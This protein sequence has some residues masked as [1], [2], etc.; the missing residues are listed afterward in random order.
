MSAG[1]S[2]RAI[3]CVLGLLAGCATTSTT[4]AA[5]EPA[6]LRFGP[7]PGEVTHEGLECGELPVPG[8]LLAVSRLRATGD[9]AERRGILLVNPGG[10]GGPGLGYAATKGAKLPP[11]V[12]RSFDVIGFDPRGVGH[13]SPVDCGPMGG[14]FDR[15]GPDPVPRTAAERQTHLDRLAALAV[16]CREGADAALATTSTVETAQDMDR[17]RAALGE[18]QISFLGVSYGTYLGM[19]Y[20]QLFGERVD[21]MVLDSVVGPGEWYDFDL[22]QARALL[23]QREVLFGWLADRHARFGLGADPAQVRRSYDRARA[24]LPAAGLGPPGAFGRAEFD[25]V[26]YRMLGR[27]ERWT[28]FGDGLRAFLRDGDLSV[29][30]PAEPYGTPEDRTYESANRV[31]KCADTMSPP[32]PGRILA[33]L[34]ALLRRDPQPVLTGIEA[35]TCAYWRTRGEAAPTGPGVPVLLVQA[36]HDPVTPAEGALQVRDALPGS[37][38]V[39]LAESW[40]HG[41]FASQRD[42]CVDDTAGTYLLTRRLPAADVTC[43]GAGLPI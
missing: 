29:L 35:D 9:S 3:A 16:D 17:I 33:E 11:E 37:R 34:D 12:R 31:V 42:P 25:R 39:T 24:A 14:L 10:P 38:L 41:V 21:A 4:A 8:A 40:S 6:P 30:A 23:A 5:P 20:A 2:L 32:P 22:A 1:A 43:T 36:A 26:V 28:G 13:S 18:E 7:C 27:T 15:P 19:R